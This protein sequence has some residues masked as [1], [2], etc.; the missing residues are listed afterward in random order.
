MN[1]HFEYK[2]LLR[3]GQ[4]GIPY[5]KKSFSFDEFCEDNNNIDAKNYLDYLLKNT[6]GKRPVLKF[7][8][9]SFR[10][11]WFKNNYPKSLNIYLTRNPRDQLQS[12]VSM[13]TKKNIDIFLTMDLITT[14]VNIDAPIFRNL[15]NRIALLEY[16]SAEY[17]D[18]EI[19]YSI[20]NGF[21][22]YEDRYYIF[23]YIWFYAFI[24]NVLYADIIVNI[25][26]LSTE[27]SYLNNLYQ[28]LSREMISDINYDD[29][30]IEKYEAYNIDNEKME[31][32]EKDIQTIILQSLRNNEL[33]LFFSKISKD[34]KNFLY[35]DKDT[36]IKFE[37]TK[38]K[39]EKPEERD[40]YFDGFT[41]I[42]DNCV[43]LSKELNERRN[44]IIKLNHRIK[45]L[46]DN[47]VQKDQQL[48]QRDRLLEQ[49]KQKIIQLEKHVS[50]IYRSNS[51]RIGRIIIYPFSIFNKILKAR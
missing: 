32:I 41:Y 28:Q 17:E 39:H 1:K 44:E 9:S 51:Y 42:A 16:H 40:K 20:L 50:N 23:Y 10:I 47:V 46:N 49:K 25:D 13:Y 29:A 33:E 14:G 19:I 35:Y 45:L 11:K 43:I 7:N 34:E 26:F 4:E 31:E 5:F 2:K 12:Y 36:A 30:N 6:N 27:K 8:R 37:Q 21:Y 48:S 24:L 15:K 18:E 3:S 38:R 22:T